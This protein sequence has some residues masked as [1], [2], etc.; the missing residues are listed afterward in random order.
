MNRQWEGSIPYLQ[1]SL[2]LNPDA[3]QSR[4]SL[5]LAYLHCGRNDE[6]VAE[7]SRVAVQ[8]PLSSQMNLA[9]TYAKLGRRDEA[10]KLVGEVLR[11]AH[12]DQARN[13][14]L[15]TIY[16][17]LG[18]KERGFELLR[19]SQLS[20]TEKALLKLDPE[21]DDVRSEPKFEAIVNKQFYPE[22]SS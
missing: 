20:W 10:H 7:F 22:Q 21:L 19:K 6:A 11:S 3:T 13:Y 8:D 18:D 16:F 4:I 5:G 14:E 17:A 2:E 1:R 9:L 15:V 12:R